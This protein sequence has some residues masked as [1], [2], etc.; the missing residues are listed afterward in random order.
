MNEPTLMD[1]VKWFAAAQASIDAIRQ[2]GAE[3]TIL[4][5][6]TCWTHTYDWVSGCQKDDPRNTGPPN[7]EASLS[8]N[9]PKNNYAF[10]VHY[11]LDKDG[12]GNNKDCTRDA[13]KDLD[14][15]TQWL[16]KNN[17]KGFLGEIGAADTNDCMDK[18]DKALDH[19]NKN[20]DVWLGYAA[21]SAGPVSLS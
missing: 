10:D 14:V 8:I 3:S 5:P 15:I 18:L 13:V 19:L 17:K 7:G 16:K 2:A 1:S 4:V 9:D 12:G 11:Y 20:S 21:W 6:G